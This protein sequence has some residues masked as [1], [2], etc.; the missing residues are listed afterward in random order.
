MQEFKAIIERVWRVAPGLQRLE[1]VMG[2]GTPQPAPGQLFLAHVEN[3][4]NSYLRQHWVP[5]AYT[6]HGFV[7]E[8][9]EISYYTPGQPVSLIGPVGKPFELPTNTRA[10][11]IIAYDVSPAAFWLLV[12]KV[13]DAGGAVTLV[14]LGQAARY[15]LQVIP[16]DVEVQ[17]ALDLAVWRDRQPLLK[18]ADQML[19]AAPAYLD[20]DFYG[21]L[22]EYCKQIRM[23]LPAGFAHVLVHPVMP[24]GVGACQACTIALSGGR[25]ANA[26]TDGPIFDLT[27]MPFKR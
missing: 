20:A 10:L 27:D 25:E 7:V 26:C 1:I 6:E 11:V 4:N 9:N 16:A 19:A 23:S 5:V 17:T 2:K 15:P 3:A 14:L 18:W 12:Q 21:E 13:L 22:A 8:R 24:C